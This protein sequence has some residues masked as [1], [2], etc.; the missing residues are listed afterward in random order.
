MV[1][2]VALVFK[3]LSPFGR[4]VPYALPLIGERG[5]RRDLV[6]EVIVAADLGHVL[7]VRFLEVCLLNV[8]VPLRDLRVE[9]RV[10]RAELCSRVEEKSSF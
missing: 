5:P 3:A 9:L 4:P 2:L 10:G 8:L 7:S 6:V 1:T